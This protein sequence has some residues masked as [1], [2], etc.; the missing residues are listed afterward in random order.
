[1][2]NNYIHVGAMRFFSVV[3][4]PEHP[5]SRSSMQKKYKV[6]SMVEM[7]SSNRLHWIA[8]HCTVVLKEN[9]Q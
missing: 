1:M 2:V 5:G 3:P 4:F 9:Y 6:F 8:M 7:R